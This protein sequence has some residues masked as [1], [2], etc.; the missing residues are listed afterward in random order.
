M[1]NAAKKEDLTLIITSSYRDYETQ[2]Y[3]WNMYADS[4]GDEYADSISARAGYSEHQTGL[5]TDIMKANW[6][7]L[8]EGDKEYTWLVDNSYKYGFILRY[9]K[10]KDNIT[11]Y[12]YEEWHFRYVDK[13]VATYLHDNNLTYD[14]Y[15][16]RN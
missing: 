5:A 4:K 1:F 3:L 15:V 13:K 11:G 7:F 8:S 12:M 10:D 16:A 6:D 9:P 14:E 2:D